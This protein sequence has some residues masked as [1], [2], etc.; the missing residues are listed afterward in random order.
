MSTAAISS[1]RCS[2]ELQ[3][4][5]GSMGMERVKKKHAIPRRTE[6][7]YEDQ[8]A[9]IEPEEVVDDA[10]D[11]G[12]DELIAGIAAAIAAYDGGS[13]NLV[14]KS[15]RRV[16]GWKNAARSEQVHFPDGSPYQ[17]HLQGFMAQT[18]MNS[19]G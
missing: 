14:V 15:V 16:N 12:T 5:S 4:N 3:P 8:L 9:E 13:R 1:A 10:Q 2:S 18:S 11:V 19:A 7:L 6:I 17:P